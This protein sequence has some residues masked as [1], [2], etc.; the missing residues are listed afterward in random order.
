MRFQALVRESASIRD[1]LELMGSSPIN[2]NQPGL[3]VVIDDNNKVI[4]TVTDGDVRRGLT[5][6]ITVDDNVS[7]IYN[8]NPLML[9]SS[10]PEERILLEL[11]YKLRERGE[12]FSRHQYIVFIKDDRTF[13]DISTVTSIFERYQDNKLVAVYGLGFVGLTLAAVFANNGAIVSGIDPNVEVIN[14]L[15]NGEPHFFEKGL[16]SLLS[17]LSRTNPIRFL[18]DYR[19]VHADIHIICVGTP[20]TDL[21]EPNYSFI[22]SVCIQI[23]E[24][25]KKVTLSS[26][27]RRYQYEQHVALLFLC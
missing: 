21:N 9:S 4:A 10:L 20:I 25:L 13:D 24:I 18:T 27:D 12:S 17:T 5:R 2:N 19:D 7:K 6:G 14:S 11:G 8:L 3:A 16:K 22:E 26:L 1:A 23:S 15:N